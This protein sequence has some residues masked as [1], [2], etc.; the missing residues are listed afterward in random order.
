VNSVTG[1]RKEKLNVLGNGTYKREVET[2]D[3][4]I[5]GSATFHDNVIT[6]GF[7]IIGYCKVLGKVVA[8]NF[9]NKGSSTVKKRLTSNELT[10]LASYKGRNN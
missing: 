10:N 2:T 4:S 7:H 9:I 6:E 5:S 8:T 3:I 1:T